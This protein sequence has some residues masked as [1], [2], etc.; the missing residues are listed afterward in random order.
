MSCIIPPRKRLVAGEFHFTDRTICTDEMGDETKLQ[1][2]RVKW[3]T[4]SS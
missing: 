2:D 1:N 3:L 4:L